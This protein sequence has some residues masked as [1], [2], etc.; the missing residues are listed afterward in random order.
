MYVF[1]MEY[2][3]ILHKKNIR[4]TTGGQLNALEGLLTEYMRFG[5]VAPNKE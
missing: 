1:P 5:H 2:R 3:G 4:V